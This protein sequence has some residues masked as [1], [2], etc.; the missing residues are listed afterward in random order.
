MKPYTFPFSTPDRSRESLTTA[1][2]GLTTT[3]RALL[4]RLS[5]VAMRMRVA[6]AAREKTS[7]LLRGAPSFPAGV[8]R[9]VIARGVFAAGLLFPAP[10]AGAA[11]GLAV[12]AAA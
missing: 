9:G 1:P 8:G 5:C 3:P 2:C 12:G 6:G 7:A 4:Q 11:G 10:A